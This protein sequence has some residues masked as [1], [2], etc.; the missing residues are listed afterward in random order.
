M[1]S[2]YRKI[3]NKYLE[4][5]S[6]RDFGLTSW[7]HKDELFPWEETPMKNI[8]N[9]LNIINWEKLG[10]DYEHSMSSHNL[11]GDPSVPSVKL[12]PNPSKFVLNETE[13]AVCMNGF[14]LE[15]GFHLGSCK[16]I[17][18]PMYLNS[19]MVVRRHY[20]LCKAP[21]HERLYKLFGLIP[22]MPSSWEC[23]PENTPGLCHLWGDDLVWSWWLHDHP[24][25]KSN[26]SS[27]FRWE[28]DHKEI[29]RVY[30]R[31]VDV[32]S[33][34]QGKRNFFYQCFNGYW[35]ERN[36]RFQ[37][38]QH[39]DGWVWNKKGKHIHHGVGIMSEDIR[40]NLALSTFEWLE[41]FKGEVVDYLLKRHFLE[42]LKI[43]E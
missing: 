6:R 28:N 12:W 4:N 16:H 31:L 17:Y 34:D 24:H 10:W 14:G 21:F 7:V 35:D 29:V 37:F 30:K 27:Q 40:E 33:H 13:C 25:N 1:V 23:N 2:K 18:H 26:I 5:N 41:R 8:N 32:G 11:R 42:T 19:F 22:Y 15:G 9:E 38:G 39:P 3:D 20:A 43:L 36:K